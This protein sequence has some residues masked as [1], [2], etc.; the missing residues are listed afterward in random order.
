M[1]K[2]SKL[3]STYED[4]PIES[5]IRFV[6][7]IDPKS[8]GF[9]FKRDEQRSKTWHFGC[10][11]VAWQ[12]NHGPVVR[13]KVFI[14][15]Q[16]LSDSLAMSLI[17]QT[18]KGR[19]IE[20]VG[21]RPEDT[22]SLQ[23]SL[24]YVRI[25]GPIKKPQKPHA[26]ADEAQ[27]QK[28][29][30]PPVFEDSVFGTL[31]FDQ[32]REHFKA[33]TSFRG[34]EMNVTFKA[35]SIDELKKLIKHARLLWKKRKTWFK[36]WRKAC[37]EYYTQELQEEWYEGEDA[38]DEDAFNAKL[39]QPAGV[40]FAMNE[41]ELHYMITGMDEDLVGDHALEAHGTNLTPDEICLT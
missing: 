27:R 25:D 35:E 13:E 32:E 18:P 23:K 3:I 34:T 20:F 26:L 16:R 6:G 2:Q 8:G 21:S 36:I 39:G 10:Q 24:W 12:A 22:K 40:D 9:R 14:R 19:I 31:K 7:W 17:R 33:D 4:V 15:K 37:F 38:L 11:L 28:A 29:S 30:K 41:G 5:K 1:A